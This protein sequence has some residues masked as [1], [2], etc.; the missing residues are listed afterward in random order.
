MVSIS[1]KDCSVAFWSFSVLGP[2]C[3]GSGVLIR[4]SLFPTQDICNVEWT[5]VLKNSW[6]NT[7]HLITH[8]QTFCFSY[9]RFCGFRS[10]KY[11]H[12]EC[13]DLWKDIFNYNQAGLS[14]VEFCTGRIVVLN[15]ISNF[16]IISGAQRNL[17][18][19]RLLMFTFFT[20]S[21]LK[22]LL[23]VPHP[24]Y[25]WINFMN[26]SA[27]SCFWEERLGFLYLQLL[28]HTKYVLGN[29]TRFLSS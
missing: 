15:L 26:F 10:L 16:Y 23:I 8:F 1:H 18:S 13:F 6:P 20:C 3:S 2:D 25:S 11:L 21:F 17:F 12:L 29:K 27:G 24:R 5:E 19:M 22:K 14:N 4:F 9:Q 7:P 28:L